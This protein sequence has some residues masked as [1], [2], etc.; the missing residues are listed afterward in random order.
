[1]SKPIEIPIEFFLFGPSV[2]A[3]IIL[4]VYFSGKMLTGMINSWKSKNRRVS[5]T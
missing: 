1:M 3:L 2:A 4:I 5:R